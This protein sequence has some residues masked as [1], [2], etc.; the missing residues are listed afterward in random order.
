MTQAVALAASLLKHNYDTSIIDVHHK[1]KKDAPSGTSL[2]LGEKIISARDCLNK[3][4]TANNIDFCSIRAGNQPARLEVMFSG[5]HESLSIIHNAYSRETFAQGALNIAKWLQ[6][7]P[8]HMYTM[9]D[10][11]ASIS[12]NR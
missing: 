2:L 3:D 7:A 1:H 6:N 4:F 11:I 9:E 10:Y 5:T 12:S 8:A